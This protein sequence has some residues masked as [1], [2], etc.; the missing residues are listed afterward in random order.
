GR[1]SR[2]CQVPRRYSRATGR[3]SAFGVRPGP[4]AVASGRGPELP[5]SP[6]G[7]PRPPRRYRVGAPGPPHGPDGRAADGRRPPAGGVAGPHAAATEVRRSAGEPVAARPR[8]L[9]TC[10]L[11]R[12]G[13]DPQRPGRV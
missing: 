7:R 4:A 10:R 5:L 9:P 2:C 13:G 6:T 1:P 8:D 12:N 3:P 11:R